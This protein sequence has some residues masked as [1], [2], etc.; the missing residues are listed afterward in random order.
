M[1]N[2]GKFLIGMILLVLFAGFFINNSKNVKASEIP[3]DFIPNEIGDINNIYITEMP[4]LE[5]NY[6]F[7]I[8]KTDYN[9]N[10]GYVDY[11]IPNDYTK[12]CISQFY[13]DFS[14]NYNDTSIEHKIN[15][16]LINVGKTTNPNLIFYQTIQ[17]YAN[18]SEINFQYLTQLNNISEGSGI[19]T[20]KDWSYFNRYIFSDNDIQLD[21][22]NTIEFNIAFKQSTD[23]D[24]EFQLILF[25]N[26]VIKQTSEIVSYEAIDDFHTLYPYAVQ[27][28]RENNVYL[29]I[30]GM[31]HLLFN[32]SNPIT[33]F[34]K[35]PTFMNTIPFP[36][37]EPETVEGEFW[38]YISYQLTEANLEHI[39]FSE[40]IEFQGTDTLQNFTY[41]F[42]M[43]EGLLYNAKFYYNSIVVKPSSMGDWSIV[44]NWLRDG[45]AWIINALLIALQFLLYLLVAGISILF[46]WLFI[47]IIIP[48]VWNVLLFWIIFGAIY[49]CFYVWIGLIILFDWIIDIL[50]PILQWIV[51]DA[52]PVIIEGLI[53]VMSWIFAL[54][55]YLISLGTGD[56]LQLQTVI[57]QFL[58]V[59]ADFFISSMVFIVKYLPEILTYVLFYFIL[60]GF[61]YLKITYTKA[62]GFVNRSNQLEASLSAYIMPVQL[63]YN[64]LVNVK[65]L[66]VM[67]W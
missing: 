37:P 52:L 67:W 55:F 53:Y 49:L 47:A 22:I 17:M 32:V 29:T 40:T 56:L 54:L 50:V 61:C 35:I 63:G 46:G 5:N 2:R 13:Y 41:D 43:T 62:R 10:T 11:Y 8:Y 27:F 58:N 1:K 7:W 44:W 57:Q 6:R 28:Y 26:G 59:I 33:D 60:I 25:I 30:D 20:L 23:L 9:N 45:I 66:M 42:Q 12:Y 18:I 65:N 21:S 4:T 24:F 31:R 15:N 38:Y 34:F 64:V 39:E 19:Q 14:G 36:I 48:F 3:L 51:V 16:R